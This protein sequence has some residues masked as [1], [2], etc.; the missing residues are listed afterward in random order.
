MY[1]AT[2]FLLHNKS[3]FRNHLNF[4][5]S[6]DFL[7]LPLS[8]L[9]VSKRDNLCFVFSFC[10]L[11]LL[12]QEAVE[13][14]PPVCWVSVLP[15]SHRMQC[16]C[17]LSW[18]LSYDQSSV[19]CLGFIKNPKFYVYLMYSVFVSDWPWRVCRVG[20]FLALNLVNAR[21]LFPW[22]RNSSDQED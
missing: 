1:W 7:P 6:L 18:L 3:N 16:C 20:R 5:W 22:T 17:F 21:D 4:I 15:G 14:K 8:P 10:L 12:Q 19:N 9:T 2:E 11:F 13:S